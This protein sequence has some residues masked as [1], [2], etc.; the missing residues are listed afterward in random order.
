MSSPQ[1]SNSPARSEGPDS[2]A[3]GRNA[4]PV[5]PDVP[6]DAPENSTPTSLAPHS[7]HSDLFNTVSD[8]FDGI[9][10]LPVDDISELPTFNSFEP[11]DS[12]LHQQD[13]GLGD[14]SGFQFDA[15]FAQHE[16]LGQDEQA[17]DHGA[18]HDASATLAAVPT[19]NLNFDIGNMDFDHTLFDC[20][21][22]T[23]NQDNADFTA[24]NS[25]LSL[26]HTLSST[27]TQDGGCVSTAE[28][29][30]A[31]ACNEKPQ[32]PKYISSD[33][34]FNF[35][36]F[37]ARFHS[38]ELSPAQQ[39]KAV[40]A[41]TEKKKDAVYQDLMRSLGFQPAK[42][43]APVL[44]GALTEDNYLPIPWEPEV[45]EDGYEIIPIEFDAPE[46]DPSDPQPIYPAF[47]G[48]FK[49][50]AAARAYRKRAR[51][52]KKGPAPDV[53]RVKKYGRMYWVRRIYDSIIDISDV[54]DS[55]KSNHL[56]RFEEEAYDSTDIEATAHHVFDEAVAVHTRGWVRPNIYHKKVVRGKLM[57]ISKTSVER[58]LAR[59]CL[60]L[61]HVKAA[62]DDA[63]RGGLTLA[64]LCDNPEARGSTKISNNSGNGKRGKRLKVVKKM[65]KAG[66]TV[67]TDDEESDEEHGENEEG[68]GEGE[69]R[70]CDEV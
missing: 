18:V 69:E 3:E 1:A 20:N 36:E 13:D 56:V 42:P 55:E 63:L 59:I 34:E 39:V 54:R 50:G 40:A 38:G 67:E 53:E 48:R 31:Q 44:E 52:P 2:H 47:S 51:V 11:I 27:Q 28:E 61:K 7:E 16:D 46:P 62:C 17:N 14:L 12:G 57:D 22:F 30:I 6:V 32:V 49:T 9:P 70:S 43:G 21:E 58:R 19:N 5:L 33:A 68:E 41:L 24:T 4:S 29:H 8:A 45:D 25:E 15:D 65:L 26:Q 35:E 23:G 64:L 37:C 60:L 66:F 10:D